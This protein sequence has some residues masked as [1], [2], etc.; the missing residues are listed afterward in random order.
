MCEAVLVSSGLRGSGPDLEPSLGRTN[1]SIIVPNDENE[2]IIMFLFFPYEAAISD[3]RF[4]LSY[5]CSYLGFLNIVFL[6]FPFVFCNYF[7]LAY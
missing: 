4:V 3:L 2:V 7:K 5:T 6:L 1:L